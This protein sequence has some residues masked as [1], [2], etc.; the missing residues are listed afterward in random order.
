VSG[1][2]DL[3]VA[4]AD[5]PYRG[6]ARK[7]YRDRPDYAGEV[8][9]AALIERLVDEFPDGWALSMGAR[10]LRDLLPLCPPDVRVMP[11]VKTFSAFKQHGHPQY[12]WEPVIVRGGRRRHRGQPMVRDWLS[13][14]IAT[15][16]GVVGAKPD[17][18]A[19]W[20]FDVLNLRAGDTFVDLFPGSGAVGRA[21]A[22]W[23]AQPPLA[24]VPP[25]RRGRSSGAMAADVAAATVLDL[26][27]AA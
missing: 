3:R 19:Y 23:R 25:R 15:K 14:P 1:Q 20:L 11:W 18:F 6:Q 17:P 4:Y 16:R 22:E 7:H 2:S 8:D 27:P 10:D 13:Y 9:Q 12:A 21:W 26:D 24:I 5:P